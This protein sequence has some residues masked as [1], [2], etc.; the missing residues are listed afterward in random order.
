MTHP[1]DPL[2]KTFNILV[3]GDSVHWGQ[4][5]YDHEKMH[6]L[7]AAALR[8]QMPDVRVRTRMLAHSGAIIGPPDQPPG[9]PCLPGPFGGEV[10]TPEPTVF[11]QVLLA[12]G[13]RTRDPTADLII[14]GGG[15]NDVYLT[16]LLNPLDTALDERI[17]EAFYV[18]LRLLTEWVL[19]RFPNAK[20]IVPGYYPYFS[21]R[22]RDELFG[23]ALAALGF[24]V[25]GLPGMLGGLLIDLLMKDSI[26]GRAVY[27]VEKAHESINLVLREIYALMPESIDRLY[28]ADPAF[29]EEH[30][31]LADESLLFGIASD[32]MPVDPQPIREGRAKA[33]ADA[34]ERLNPIERFGCP[35]ASVGHPNPLGA[36]RYAAAILAQTRLALP[37]LWDGHQHDHA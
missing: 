10:P 34:S 19:V 28:F 18:R 2:R 14:L 30:A 35:R 6:N 20:V 32:L 25:A 26:K 5:L 15:I 24:G 8:E 1:L 27:F 16:N 37:K 31:M 23:V 4:G 12:L 11:Q 36:Q 21:R 33:C 17:K 9:L 22:T 13:K 29:G 7:V 3:F